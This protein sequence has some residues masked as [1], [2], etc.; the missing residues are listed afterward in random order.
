MVSLHECLAQYG[1]RLAMGGDWLISKCL[2]QFV[3]AIQGAQV[4]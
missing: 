4:V 3:I 2:I 1:G